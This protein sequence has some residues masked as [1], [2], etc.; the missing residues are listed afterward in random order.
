MA[1]STACGPAPSRLTPFY[2]TLSAGG[3][4]GGLFVAVV[5]PFVFNAYYGLG[6]AL[7]A[8]AFL[9]ARRFAGLGRIAR[10]VTL[11]VLFR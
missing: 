1:S 11:V 9:A 5:G 8:L 2:L 3:A 7:L 10:Y 6:L 4:L